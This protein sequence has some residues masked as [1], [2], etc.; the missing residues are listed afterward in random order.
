MTAT[1]G[2]VGPGAMGLGI[3]A[4][5][6]RAGVRVVA[7]DIRP[8]ANDRAKAAGATIAASPAEVAR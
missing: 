5:L 6:V 4:S 1:V 8:E 2:V 3:V 7:R